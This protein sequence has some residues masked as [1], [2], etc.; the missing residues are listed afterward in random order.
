[1]TVA[2]FVVTVA[3]VAGFQTFVMR[4]SLGRRAAVIFA[5][6]L[7][8][9]LSLTGL[10]AGLGMLPYSEG[11]PSPAFA[12]VAIGNVAAA[13]FA[14]SAPGAR[15]AT[16]VPLAWLIGLQAFRIPVEIGLWRLFHDGT[17]PIHMTFEGRNPDILT[18]LFAMILAIWVA[19][20]GAP[21][22]VVLGWNL[23]GVALLVNIVTVAILCFP[24]PLHLL[25]GAPNLVLVRAPF[26]WLPVFLVPTALWGHILVARRLRLEA[27]SLPL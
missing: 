7:A 5:S 23:L 4:R 21:R 10:L 25:D 9:W 20:R 13:A 18:G 15:I 17:V 16:E 3:V 1:M 27:A 24:G 14:L 19:F 8:A 6:V 12:F 22:L 2:L 26:V 11:A